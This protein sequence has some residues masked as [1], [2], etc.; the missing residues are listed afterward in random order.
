[1]LGLHRTDADAMSVK[2][3]RYHPLCMRRMR[4][5]YICRA[6][7]YTASGCHKAIAGRLEPGPARNTGSRHAQFDGRRIPRCHQLSHGIVL[8]R[9]EQHSSKCGWCEADRSRSA[10]KWAGYLECI[11]MFLSVPYSACQ[12]SLPYRLTRPLSWPGTSSN[13]AG[14]PIA[15]PASFCVMDV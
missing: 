4:R 2:I 10:S 13:L 12:Q 7:M 5:I 3:P 6:R 8:Q 1:M 11:D 9:L 15:R 14:L